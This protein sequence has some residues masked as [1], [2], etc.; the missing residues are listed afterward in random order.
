M[1]KRTLIKN[2]LYA[3]DHDMISPE[4]C[5]YR[6]TDETLDN[7]IKYDYPIEKAILFLRDVYKTWIYKINLKYENTGKGFINIYARR[8]DKFSCQC[9]CINFRVNIDL[10]GYDTVL[11]KLSC[12]VIG[13]KDI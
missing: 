12:G 4:K 11:D 2:L 6:Y 9:F 8:I 5:E 3:I 7:Y 1:R 10:W 13:S